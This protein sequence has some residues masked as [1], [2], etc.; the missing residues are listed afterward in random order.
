[1]IEID[2]SYLEG[3]GQIIRT[4]L[5]LSAITQK[6]FHAANVRKGREKPGLKNQHLFSVHAVQKLCNA[7]VEGDFIGSTELTFTPG[8]IEG[9]TISIDIQTAGS[10]ALLLQAI[11]PPSMFADKKVH[12]K[13]IGGTCGTHAAPYEYFENVLLPHLKKFADIKSQLV[14]RGYFPKGNGEIDLVIKPKFTLTDDIVSFSNL[15]ENGPRIIL[16]EQCNLISI[17]GISHASSD[18]EN[19]QVAER[20]AKGARQMLTS[21]NVP[22]SIRTEYSQ[23]LSTGSGITLWAIFSKDQN[24]IDENNPIRL[25]SDALGERGKRAETVGEEAASKLKGYINSKAPADPHFADQ[26]LPFMALTSNSIIKTAEITNH[27]RTN[28]YT[29]EK[30]LGK[31]FGVDDKNKIISTIS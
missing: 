10:V 9:K 27:A 19:A 24:E 22:I 21:F 31:V 14:R 26:I 25:G 18:L 2:G 4:A 13:I 12:L 29:I 5:A 6:P 23:T 16:T 15:K 7:K 11:L 8:P 30:F 20:Q 3:G 28:I 17:K 1:M